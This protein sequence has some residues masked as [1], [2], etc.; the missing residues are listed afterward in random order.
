LAE[1]ISAILDEA[2]QVG[3]EISLFKRQTLDLGWEARAK[4]YCELVAPKM[5]EMRQ[6]VDALE[7]LV[8]DA[9]W[10]LPKYRELLF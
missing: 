1:K 7:C 5:E 4:V 10:P 6:R 2:F 8:E 3:E 9:R